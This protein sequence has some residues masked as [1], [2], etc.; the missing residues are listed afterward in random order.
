MKDPYQTLGVER[1]AS[2]AQIK[3]SYRKLAKQLHPD[4]NPGKAAIELRFKEV[5]AAYD[6]LSDAKKRAKYDSGQIDASGSERPGAGFWRNWKAQ[7]NP[8][9]RAR[10][11]NPFSDILDDDDVFADLFRQ[12]RG[13]GRGG[14]GAGKGGSGSAAGGDGGRLGAEDVTYK[15]KVPFVE[16]LAGVKKRVTLSDG[17]SVDLKVPAGTETGSKLRLKGQGRGTKD[18]IGDAYIDI[19]VEPHEFFERDGND[20]LVDIPIT[21]D[22]AVLGGSIT[23]PTIHGNVTLKVPKASNS[24]S[25]LRLKG[26]GVPGIGGKPAGDQ[27]ATLKIVLPE[28]ENLELIKFVQEWRE[29]NGYNP[30]HRMRFN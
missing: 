15:L 12:A 28:G 2:Q 7:P 6:I 30:R 22:E 4:L 18:V 1:N 24:G 3:S 10:R 5:S 27:Y 26:K 19:T 17:R 23:L 16:A 14:A 20:I 9:A 11:N 29:N 21:L 13:G 25:R 8:S